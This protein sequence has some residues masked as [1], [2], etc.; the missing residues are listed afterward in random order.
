MRWRGWLAIISLLSCT[1]ITN[2]GS[3]IVQVQVLAP[4]ITFLD[5]TDTTRLFA[6]ALDQNGQVVSAAIE[7]VAFDTTVTV[8]QSGLV[9]AD[10]PGLAR[11]RAQQGNLVSNTISLTVVP[12]PDTIVIEGDDTLRVL[13]GE[14]GTN[15]LVTRVDS[16]HGVDTIPANG[17]LVIYEVVEPVF[18]D[19][20]QRSVEF[21]GQVLVDTLTSGQNGTPTVPLVLNRVAGVTSPDSAIV[22]MT[23]LRFVHATAV[24]DSTIVT[25]ADTVPGSGLQF[26]VRF[27]NP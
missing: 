26:I 2:A 17:A 5:V 15:P 10:Q 4:I 18:A 1:D 14:G 22:Q 13:V 23:G 20:S 21:T 27:D 16:Y 7:W 6:R 24:D 9:Q 3:D 25:T 12:R 19:P 8:D 11:V